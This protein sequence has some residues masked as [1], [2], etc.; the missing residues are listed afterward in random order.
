MA[1]NGNGRT[2]EQVINAIKEGR[3]FASKAADI[4]G[5]SRSTF[6]TDLKK[7][8]TAQQALEDV[9][10]S[11]HDYVESK[12]LQ[13]VDQGNMTA[14]IFYL[15]TQCK[16]RGYVERVEQEHRGTKKD[17]GID[18]NLSWGDDAPIDD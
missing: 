14:I 12:L 9:R 11:R 5:V 2:A 7:F 6:Y 8:A 4:L 18:I 17:G 1:K 10:E 16:E 15:K 13:G 3:G